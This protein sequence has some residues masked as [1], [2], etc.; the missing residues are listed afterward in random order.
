MTYRFLF[1]HI[2][3]KILSE[4]G[5]TVILKRNSFV[6][7][8]VMTFI[9]AILGGIVTYIGIPKFENAQQPP[10]SAPSWLFPVVWSIL[11]LLMSVGA[12]VIYDSDDETSGKA[13][14]LYTIQLTLNFWW[15]VLF[16]GFRLYFFSF[17]WLL[18]LL[19][20]VFVMTVLFCRISKLAGLIQIPYML[21]LGF[22]AYLN[23]GVW[24]LNR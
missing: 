16:F 6:F 2:I 4:K 9:F 22:A 15:C 18:L 14:L 19:L 20:T 3:Y 24:F 5:D 7:S 13:L 23:F 1:L 8:F 17:I 21:W 12:A 10:L 11:F